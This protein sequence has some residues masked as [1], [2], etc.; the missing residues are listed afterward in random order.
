VWH[1]GLLGPGHFIGCFAGGINHK[2]LTDDI[3]NY[4][5]TQLFPQNN[6]I[7]P[8]DKINNKA[9]YI[10]AQQSCFEYLGQIYDPA[11]IIIHKD[12]FQNTEYINTFRMDTVWR[13]IINIACVDNLFQAH[14]EIDWHQRKN[15]YS[16]HV[17][18]GDYLQSSIHNI[19]YSGQIYKVITG[20]LT[21]PANSD[22]RFIFFTD[23]YEL[24]T[25]NIGKYFPTDEFN[26]IRRYF[27]INEPDPLNTLR[28]MSACSKGHILSNSSFSIWGA[29]LNPNPDKQVY[30]P[31]KWLNSADGADITDAFKDISVNQVFY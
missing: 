5:Q 10:D 21:D 13:H 24:L 28:L 26:G 17:R 14:N 22:A 16:V 18:L 6:S 23:D 11:K 12:Y 9:K 31:R 4:Y 2:Q 30:L 15:F 25:K 1:Y 7:P 3:N 20:L 27:I 8:R 19:D 29:I